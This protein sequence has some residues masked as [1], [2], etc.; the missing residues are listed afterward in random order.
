M[1]N[2]APGDE[3]V[4]AVQAYLDSE[5]SELTYDPFWDNLTKSQV[6]RFLNPP[7]HE[8]HVTGE[9]FRDCPDYGSELRRLNLA[10]SIQE[11]GDHPCWF[12][13]AWKQQATLKVHELV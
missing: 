13:V 3:Q 2:N 10:E 9:F 12:I 4:E 6:F 11:A 1:T 5:L 8:I 7:H